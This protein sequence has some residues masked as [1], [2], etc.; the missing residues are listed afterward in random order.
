MM[1]FFNR[2]SDVSSELSADHVPCRVPPALEIV[3]DGFETEAPIV[4]PA[5]NNKLPCSETELPIRA[6]LRSDS[7]LPKCKKS[8]TD[9]EN[10]DPKRL[11][12]VTENELLNLVIHRT[13]SELP[14]LAKLR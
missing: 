4:A 5:A 11:S 3:N 6:K 10:T 13:E 14:A 2:R 1:S 12:P 7:E 8:S 9:I